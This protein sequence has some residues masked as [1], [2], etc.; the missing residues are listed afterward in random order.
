MRAAAVVAAGGRGE[1][2]AGEAGALPKGLIELAGRPLVQ[3]AVRTLAEVAGIAQIVVVHPSGARDAFA[4]AVG[5]VAAVELVE[6]GSTRSDSVRRGVSRVR[7]PEVTHIAIHDAARALTPR[8][9]FE[10]TLAEVAGDVVAAAPGVPVADTLKRASAEGDV[11]STADRSGLWA[12][13]TPQVVRRDVLVRVLEWS[14]DRVETDD[15]ALVEQALAAGVVAGRV[16]LV[17]GS[18][19]GLKI[20]WPADVAVAEALLALEPER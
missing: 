17:P 15:L 8:A 12:V 20:T 4:H 16:R 7:D 9:V 18:P 13:Q 6:G 2:L 3:H 14:G 10:R 11:A 5:D 19:L 1:R